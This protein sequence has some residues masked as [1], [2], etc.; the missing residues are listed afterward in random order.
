MIGDGRPSEEAPL[1]VRRVLP[2]EDVRFR[3]IG[4]D[5]DRIAHFVPQAEE[6]RVVRD[7]ALRLTGQSEGLAVFLFDPLGHLRERFPA[8]P[9]SPGRVAHRVGDEER[10]QP[11]GG[12]GGIAARFSHR[13]LQEPASASTTL[14]RK[15]SSSW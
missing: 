12:D 2:I 13:A 3:R 15:A 4:L 14:W 1:G 6:H 8:R 5:R 7:Q 11:D 10:D 9:L